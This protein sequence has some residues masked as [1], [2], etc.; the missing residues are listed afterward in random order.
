MMKLPQSTTA[1]VVHSKALNRAFEAACRLAGTPL[2]FAR[3]FL[4]AHGAGVG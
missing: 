1:A 3:L 4:I 2:S